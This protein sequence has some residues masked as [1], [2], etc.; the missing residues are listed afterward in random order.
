MRE[1]GRLEAMKKP[2]AAPKPAL[3][4]GRHRMRHG[5]SPTWCVACGTFDVWC[6]VIACRPVAKEKRW[7]TR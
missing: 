5:N 3:R 2:L 1:S 4:I 6:G 7:W